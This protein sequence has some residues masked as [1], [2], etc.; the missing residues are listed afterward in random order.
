M[1][2]ILKSV[3]VI[4]ILALGACWARS[5][6][7]LIDPEYDF[8]II[9]EVDGEATGHA[10]LV[11]LGPDTTYIRSVR[12]SCGCTGVSF[13]EDPLAP[14]DTTVISFSYDP[15]GRL[16][17]FTKTV[18][19]YVGDDDERHIVRLKGRVVGSAKSL[20]RNYP[21]ECGRLRLSDKTVEIRDVKPG[22]GRHAFIRMV[23]QSMDTVAPVW[24]GHDKAL[25]LDVTPTRLAPGEIATFGI[26]F[27]TRF[28]P[29]RGPVEYVIPF[30]AEGDSAFTD[31]TIRANILSPD[32]I[33]SAEATK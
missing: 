22:A 16:G 29:R 3:F 9:R 23:N 7:K 8:G 14:G 27:N 12:P 13:F 10:R 2:N 31:I 20:A 11:N 32:S 30:K 4:S 28:E 25:S 26:F 15:A 33:Q 24:E 19:V 21:V 17:N 1:K 5:A 18:K 6:V